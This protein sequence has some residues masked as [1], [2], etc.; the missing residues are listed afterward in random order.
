MR[1]LIALAATAGLAGAAAA[2]N[3]PQT[4]WGKAGISFDDY[5]SD[6][7]FCVRV[8]ASTDLTGTEPANALVLASRRMAAG[9]TNDYTPAIGGASSTSPATIMGGFDPMI[10]A[11]N[12]M[13]QER[14]AARPDLRIR[15]AHDIMQRRLDHC[16]AGRGYHRFRLTDDQRRRLRRFPERAAERQTYLYSLAS[17]PQILAA[18]SE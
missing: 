9:Q 13:Q 15:Q 11:A 4:S 14:I 8:A 18:Q 2:A 16:L 10:E 17:D 6:A 5:R 7:T 12:R 3:A 1:I